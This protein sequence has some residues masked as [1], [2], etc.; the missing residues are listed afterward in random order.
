MYPSVVQM[1]V[2]PSNCVTALEML[3]VVD[4]IDVHSVVDV[5]VVADIW[6]VQSTRYW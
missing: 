3:T 2:V 5:D 4:C 1:F 6:F